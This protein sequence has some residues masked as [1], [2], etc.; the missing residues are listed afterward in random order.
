MHLF[1][2][3]VYFLT[4]TAIITPL[5]NLLMLNSSTN[6]IFYTVRLFNSAYTACSKVLPFTCAVNFGRNS[7]PLASAVVNLLSQSVVTFSCKLPLLNSADGDDV[8]GSLQ[9][10]V[11]LR[12]FI[13]K[14]RRVMRSG[15]TGATCG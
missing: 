5:V 2:Y 7:R 13:E 8:L 10:V 15:I 11:K 9:S 6:F 4:P 1:C 12:N 3:S 14:S